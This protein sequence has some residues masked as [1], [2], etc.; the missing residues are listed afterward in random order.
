[1][2]DDQDRKDLGQTPANDATANEDLGGADVQQARDD[3]NIAGESQPTE[4][5]DDQR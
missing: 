2:T 5:D 4:E 1:M 3:A